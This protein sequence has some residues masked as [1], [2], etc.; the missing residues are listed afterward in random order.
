LALA[1]MPTQ[2]L[3][4]RL[5]SFGLQC[6]GSNHTVPFNATGLGASVNRFIVGAE[7]AL[8]RPQGGIKSLRLQ[9]GN[10]NRT[11]LVMGFNEVSSR[12]VFTNFMAVPTTAAGIITFHP[13]GA[14]NG[15]GSLQGLVNIWFFS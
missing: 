3:E 4:S 15:G 9:V 2:A 1:A 6:D 5:Q 8:A 11:L 10:S 14:C 7:V 13:I 12:V